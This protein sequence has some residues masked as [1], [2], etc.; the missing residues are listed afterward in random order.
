M[1]TPTDAEAR[2]QQALLAALD[3]APGRPPE[4]VGLGL[5]ERG[6][7]AVRGLQAY[8][9]NAHALAERALAA[10][11]PTVQAM[12]GA[13]DFAQLARRHWQTHPPQRGDIGEWGDDLPDAIE[14]EAGLA[15]WP[16]LADAARLD[17]ALHRCERAADASVD[18][19]SLA[20]LGEADPATLRL[21]PMPGFAVIVSRHPIATIHAA[22]RSDETDA[23]VP[24]RAAI[25]AGR[26]E[27]VCVFRQGWR[28]IVQAVDAPTATW[29]QALLQGVTLAEALDRAGSGFDFA[30][31]L[32][33]A[34][35]HGWLK[36]VRLSTD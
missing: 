22:H 27:S 21:V 17:L 1:S 29:L 16:W 12:L 9:A 31:W 10:T 28:A 2:R 32:A 6:A 20:W 35:E 15:A 24:V 14:A 13:D 36:A 8:R 34:L 5:R 30:A 11:L 4:G 7:R 3:A 25:A 18:A 33:Q 19:A 26:G 23:F